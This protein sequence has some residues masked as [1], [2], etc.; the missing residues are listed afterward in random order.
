M[1]NYV[2]SHGD[3]EKR[4]L[5]NC[6]TFFNEGRWREWLDT[7]IGATLDDR[8]EITRRKQAEF[9]Q[10]KEREH[11]ESKPMPEHMRRRGSLKGIK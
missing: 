6:A 8:A 9:E 1:H 2:I 7:P 4:F 10:Q 5:K 11:E 3:N